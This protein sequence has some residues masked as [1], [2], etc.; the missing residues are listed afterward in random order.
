MSY[1]TVIAGGLSSRSSIPSI[2]VIL[3]TSAM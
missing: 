1:T 2:L 3:E